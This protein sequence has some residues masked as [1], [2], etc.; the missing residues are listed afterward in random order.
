[1]N[2]SDYDS[3]MDHITFDEGRHQRLMDAL[4]SGGRAPA[5]R[6]GR[7]IYGLIAVAACLALVFASVRLL[8]PG[9]TG[10]PMLDGPTPAPGQAAPGGT[11]TAGLPSAGL[12]GP[13]PAPDLKAADDPYVL[14]PADP[15]DGQAHSSPAI[16]GVEFDSDA[17]QADARIIFPDGWF[18]QRLTREDMIYL[19]GG[20][21]AADVPW[22]LYWSG[23][24]VTGKA[25]YDGQG[26]LWQIRL[27]GLDR[28]NEHN[29]F[30]LKLA[31]GQLPPD[32][33]VDPRQTATELR[34]V[35]VYGSVSGFYGWDGDASYPIYRIALLNGGAGLCFEVYHTDE[36]TAAHL[37]TQAA[38]VFTYENAIH[39]DRLLTYAGEVP[40]WRSE[41]L[42][43][44]QAMAEEGYVPYVT[45]LADNLPGGFVF[46]SAR[47]EL[48]QNRDYLTLYWMQGYSYVSAQFYKV[49]DLPNGVMDVN[50]KE[51]YDERLYTVPYADSVPDEVMFGGFQ[52]PVFNAADLTLDVMESRILYKGEAEDW[53][54]Q[55][56]SAYRSGL[57]GNFSVL[58]PDGVLG[59]FSFSGVTPAE[60][61]TMVGGTAETM[62][63][64]TVWPWPEGSSTDP[65]SST[66][67]GST[68]PGSSTGWVW[69]ADGSADPTFPVRVYGAGG[70]SAEL[71]PADI[72]VLFSA[73]D[74]TG[75][76][77]LSGQNGDLSSVLLAPGHAWVSENTKCICDYSLELGGGLWL[78]YHSDCGT[79]NDTE[80]NRSLTLSAADRETVNAI[81]SA[82]GLPTRTAP[83]A[84][85]ST[86]TPAIPACGVAD[87]TQNGLHYHDGVCYQGYEPCPVEDCAI[88]GR[89]DHGGVTYC[90]CAQCQEAGCT[91]TGLHYHGGTC[92]RGHGNVGAGNGYHGG[93][94][95]DSHH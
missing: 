21:D 13:T 23:Y 4:R 54:S 7:V 83:E 1:M 46:D 69:M 11:P 81:L 28:A 62:T 78:N 82:L 20:E 72:R 2:K 91:Q 15:F 31:P 89:H 14:S 6:S 44:D 9:G 52:N 66:A 16:L 8:T 75:A 18:E 58:Y 59:R 41:K 5:G 70:S 63:A 94:H 57:R 3:Y 64:P 47:R 61:L 88:V 40:A 55:P 49:Y 10:D 22:M 12:V 85:T 36:D 48:G 95:S 86:L 24:D 45:R 92:Y 38:N 68:D 43:L 32:C 42:T 39:L 29:T 84:P 77:S 76:T 27:F 74:F 34:G 35:Q 65:G 33:C 50:N 25:I 60:A 37:A 19:L 67:G 26:Q 80:N 17:A 87:C 79:F 73:L 53:Q 51:Y 30:T 71:S 93:H 90:G 56:E